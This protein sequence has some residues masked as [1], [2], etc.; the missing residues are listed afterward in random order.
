MFEQ[1]RNDQYWHPNFKASIPVSL[2]VNGKV[3]PPIETEGEISRVSPTGMELRCSKKIPI[4]AR[5]IVRFTLDGEQELEAKVEFVTR[6]EKS[7]KGW[8][9]KSESE[10]EFAVNFV[11]ISKEGCSKFQTF[12]HRLLYNGSLPKAKFVQSSS[13]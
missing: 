9:W 11:D 6:V 13:S 12:F 4:P 2:Y 3:V 1:S 8:F 5:G 7:W 10:Y